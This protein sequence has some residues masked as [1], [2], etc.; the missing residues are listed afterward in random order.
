MICSGAMI[1][2]DCVQCIAPIAMM[3]ADCV[4]CCLFPFFRLRNK[5]ASQNDSY[6]N[7][8]LEVN[9]VSKNQCR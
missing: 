4:Q 3:V 5:N 8:F 9:F 6:S 2:A 7:D 1:F